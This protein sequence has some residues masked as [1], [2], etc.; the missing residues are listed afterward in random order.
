MRSQ[1][2]EHSRISESR[3]KSVTYTSRTRTR[4]PMWLFFSTSSARLSSVNS[5]PRV[6][7]RRSADFTGRPLVCAFGNSRWVRILCDYSGRRPPVGRCGRQVYQMKMDGAQF[8][9]RGPVAGRAIGLTMM[10]MSCCCC[11]CICA[12]IHCKECWNYCSITHWGRSLLAYVFLV[13][14]IASSV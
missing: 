14:E 11:C 13:S 2:N 4:P 1:R 3:A 12:V 10:M 9:V 7:F 6:F 8:L 5:R